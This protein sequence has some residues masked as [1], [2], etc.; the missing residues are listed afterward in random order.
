MGVKVRPLAQACVIGLLAMGAAHA[1]QAAAGPGAPD[2]ATLDAVKVTGSR[3][4]SHGYT[5]ATP[6][7]AI[8]R[9]QI[10]MAAPNNIA[11]YVNTLPSMVGDR[12]TTAGNNAI[13]SGTTGMNRLNLRGL[14][15][16]RTLVLVDGRRHVGSNLQG[17]VDVN[18][19][20]N[21]LVRAVDVVTG[22]ASS[23][24]G[25]DAV[26]GVVNFQL[27][28]RY[29]GT[30][31]Y[32]QVGQSTYGDDDQFN[33]GATLGLPLSGGRGHLL[34]NA[35][36][37]TSDGVGSVR[38][39][40]W[41]NSWGTMVNPRRGAAGEPERIVVP[42]LN[43]PNE[44]PG[45]LIT[46]GPLQWTTFDPDGSPRRFD[47]GI[48]DP[49]G[50]GSSG[51]EMD[52][53]F[54]VVSLKGASERNNVFTRASFEVGEAFEVFAEA[55]WARSV[56]K[57]NASYNYFG[58]NQTIHADNAYLHPQLR[59]AM[60]ANGV[61]SVP[62]GLVLGVASPE[63][64]SRT[65][66]V[67]LGTTGLVGGDWELDAYYQYG[68]SDLHTQVHNTANTARMARA[69]DAVVDPATGRVVCRSGDG[70]V[71]LNPFGAGNASAEALAYVFGTPFFKQEMEQ[72]VF[73]A[74]VSGVPLTLD[75]GD[76]VTAFGVEHRRES[77]SGSTDPVSPDRE[78]LFGNFIATAGSNRVSEAFAELLMPVLHESLTLNAAARLADYSYSGSAFTWKAGLVWNPD[79]QWMVR[80]V[81]SRDI[82]APNL[83]DLYQTGATQRQN[84]NDPWNGNIRRN[85]LRVSTG[86]LD[87]RPEVADT[88][89]LGV[90]FSPDAVPGLNAALDYYHIEI[91]DAISTLNNQQ[92]VDRC[93]EGDP[94]ICRYVERDASGALS[95]LTITPINIAKAVMRGL[96]IDVSWRRAVPSL[97]Q[98]ASVE[99]R[100]L[101]TRVFEY[102]SENPYSV[103]EQ[104]GENSGS[105]PKL[106]A[107]ASAMFQRGPLRLG[108]NARFISSGVLNNDWV[109]GVDIDDNQVPSA[110]YLGLQGA[111]RFADGKWELYAK[112]DN[113]LNRDPVVTASNTNGFNP[114]LYDVLG[115]YYS[116]GVRYEF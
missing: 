49:T 60:Q 94:E 46:S 13:S 10:D 28:T 24:Y 20:P 91:E 55:G 23:V 67:M 19:I 95:G 100:G 58:G 40:P 29:T 17:N 22:G 82:R 14:G 73:S 65:T 105:T 34:F 90:V 9:E 21:A 47:P 11:D 42:R 61:D 18:V 44:A 36:H 33:A 25:S 110:W 99:L 92:M 7:T 66:R 4:I 68:S 113:A 8:E 41:F 74:S 102:R 97:G 3:V 79:S 116:L 108:A 35:E 70:C 115:R 81:R 75:A 38:E 54:A 53:H 112:V 39:R 69:L 51:G 77:V 50:S 84:V 98:D 87:L 101:A 111:Y 56:V 80:G 88:Y 5:S 62:F 32:V 83:G 114:T 96:D 15:A 93:F 16:D 37:A 45:G 27:D 107:H 30:K 104:T 71:P 63:V 26:A 109:Q 85:I 76:V 52:G 59:E 31:G 86:N 43:R 106:R 72:H 48:V 2:A 89:S 103:D 64:E 6:V 57:T 1:E 12:T 78:W